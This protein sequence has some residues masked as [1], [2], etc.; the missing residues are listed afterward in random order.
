MAGAGATKSVSGSAERETDYATI[1]V[2]VSTH[3]FSPHQTV[4]IHRSSRSVNTD[5]STSVFWP[6]DL[7]NLSP[8]IAL[9]DIPRPKPKPQASTWTLIEAI[10]DLRHSHADIA[11]KYFISTSHDEKHH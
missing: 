2:L 5:F 6:Q 3:K 10:S 8:S 11:S 4:K 7:D 1:T 9:I